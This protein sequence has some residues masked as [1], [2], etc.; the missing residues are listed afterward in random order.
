MILVVGASGMLGGM[1]AGQ[2]LEQGKEVRVLQRSN[3]AYESLIEAGA[4]GVP[5]DL[6]DRA[7][8]DRACQ[9][10]EIIITTATAALRGGADTFTSVDQMGTKNLIEAA[11]LANVKQF[12]YVSAYGSDIDS[13]IPL[14]RYKGE[15]EQRLRISGL[16]YT[17]LKP[18]I[19]IEVWVGAVV[20]IPL[21]A[22]APVT[23]IEGG[24]KRHSFIS[25][26]DVAAVALAAVG[27]S[28]AFN[29]E[30]A[31]GGTPPVSW[32]QITEVVGGVM[33]RPLQVRS[34]QIGE[35]VPMLPDALWP[36]LYAT[37]TYE[38]A[39]DM[40]DVCQTFGLTLTPLEDSIRRLFGGAA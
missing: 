32:S 24:Q 21:K 36:L 28:A 31:I 35:P 6:K 1:I 37:E 33:Q 25:V 3:P 14:L 10:V 8:L 7:S 9:G 39:I 2:L 19:F 11:A 38:T 13:A 40:T 16:N 29:R 5:G 34:V 26:G 22:G 20:G 4:E 17:I 30:I 27:N 23:L 12:I 18:H 15:C